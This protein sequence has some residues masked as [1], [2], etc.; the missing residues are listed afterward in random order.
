MFVVFPFE[1]NKYTEV[2]KSTVKE[3]DASESNSIKDKIIFW[4]WNF[5]RAKMKEAHRKPTR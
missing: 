1:R 2:E 3:Y 5:T 4:L